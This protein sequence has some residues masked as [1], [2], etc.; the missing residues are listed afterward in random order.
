MQSVQSICKGPKHLKQSIFQAV[1]NEAN[2][3]K[4]SKMSN[5]SVIRANVIG[6]KKAPNEG[7]CCFIP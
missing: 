1:K 2:H 4:I 5:K 6:D 7:T 3:K